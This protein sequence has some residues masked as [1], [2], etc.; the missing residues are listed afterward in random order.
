ME[1]DPKAGI[2]LKLEFNKLDDQQKRELKNLFMDEYQSILFKIFPEAITPYL[3]WISIL[4]SRVRDKAKSKTQSMTIKEVLDEFD[5]TCEELSS[6]LNYMSVAALLT[7]GETTI[8]NFQAYRQVFTKRVIEKQDLTEKIANLE[9]N[10]GYQ[11]IMEKA[12]QFSYGLQVLFLL[13]L[14]TDPL[15]V[16]KEKDQVFSDFTN[17]VDPSGNLSAPED[18]SRIYM[19][20]NRTLHSVNTETVISRLDFCN[21][22]IKNLRI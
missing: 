13:Y 14:M 10:T 17:I 18:A 6:Y 5:Y 9:T 16:R 12:G 22:M 11:K 2:T 1:T 20:L 19:L 7:F 3:H 4:P 8:A 15:E 21:E